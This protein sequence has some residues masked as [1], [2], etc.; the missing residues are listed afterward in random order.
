M[1]YIDFVGAV[2]TSTPRDYLLRVTEADK[3]ECAEKAIQWD[4]D[5]W[6]GDRKTGYGGFYYDGRWRPV[7]EIM[8]KHYGLPECTHFRCRLWERISYEFTQVLPDCEI[9][10]LDISD[11]AIEHAK[12]EVK[13]S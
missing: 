4:Y 13:P 1:A 10:G 3:A 6:D 7:A 9:V 12:D 2:H 5:Y 11:Y 8:A